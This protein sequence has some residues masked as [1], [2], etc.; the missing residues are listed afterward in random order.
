MAREYAEGLILVEFMHG[1]SLGGSVCC[2]L[3]FVHFLLRVLLLLFSLLFMRLVQGVNLLIV[4]DLRR[5]Q[6]PRG[7]RSTLLAINVV[8]VAVDIFAKQY[9]PI[10]S[11][12]LANP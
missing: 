10:Y 1:V 11:H 7:S 9:T 12:F 6:T 8:A 3:N 5:E 2:Y 4:D